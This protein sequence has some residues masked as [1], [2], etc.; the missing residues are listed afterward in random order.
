MADINY[1]GNSRIGLVLVRNRFS[2]SRKVLREDG[3]NVGARRVLVAMENQRR[4]YG[5][6][7]FLTWLWRWIL[8]VTI[9]YG[10]RP[11]YALLWG[12]AIVT[13]GSA[14]FS[15]GYS[16][17]AV[18][19]TDKEAYQV[20]ETHEPKQGEHGDPPWYYEEFSA[21]VYTLDTFL[22]IINLGEKDHWMPNAHQGGFGKFL[23]GYLWVHIG[24]GWLLT[25]LFVT[26][27]ASVVLSG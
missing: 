11:W 18:T 1:P 9:S 21:P 16:L 22:P 5:K 6:L 17:G 26:G 13:L 19:P 14:L 2:N 3:D 12:L 27:L 8:R 7:N 10:Y 20:F 15:R 25:T 4:K 23:R 24:L